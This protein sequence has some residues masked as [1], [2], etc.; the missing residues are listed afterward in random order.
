MKLSRTDLTALR[1]F[2]AVARNRGFAQ[3]QVE[4]GLSLS[5]ISNHIAALEERL[6]V[7]LCDRGRSG[8]MLTQKGQYVLDAARTLFTSMDEFTGAMDNLRDQLVG[9]LRIGIVDAI[10]T[11]PVMRLPD[12]LARFKSSAAAVTIEIFE[13]TPNVLQERVRTGDLHLGIGSF[14]FKSGGIKYQPLYSETH[15]V[16]C[17]DLHPL[18]ERDDVDISPEEVRNWPVVSRGYWRDDILLQLGFNNVTATSYQIEPQ[19]ILI[20]S[21][22]YL[23][24]LPNHYAEQWTKTGRLRQICPDVLHYACEF[25]LIQRQSAPKSRVV[26]RFAAEVL[27][28]HGVE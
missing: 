9:N 4:T 15:G 18:Y 7:R 22:R 24:F 12:A 16:F 26:S 25:D 14:A 10:S 20:L 8:F 11:D 17:S 23:G 2:D 5:S 13:D 27:A 19:L 6:G 1:V 28:A 3:A 21:G